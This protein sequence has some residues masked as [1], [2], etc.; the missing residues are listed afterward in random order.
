MLTP[1]LYFH[2]WSK[3]YGRSLGIE[4]WAGLDRVGLS[5]SLWWISVGITFHEPYSKP[6]AV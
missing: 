5:L 3:E 4:L 2:P 1:S 6:E